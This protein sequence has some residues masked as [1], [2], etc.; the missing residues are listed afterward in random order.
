[1]KKLLAISAVLALSAGAV[2]TDTTNIY[3]NGVTH[4]NSTSWAVTDGITIGIN[5]HASG[6]PN[7]FSLSQTVTTDNYRIRQRGSSRTSGTFSSASYSFNGLT[8]TTG[9]RDNH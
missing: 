3:V 6:A 1:M 2:A 8:A 9:N 5:N 4:S 7:G